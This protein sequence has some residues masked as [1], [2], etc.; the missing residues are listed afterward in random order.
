MKFSTIPSR[1]GFLSV[2]FSIIFYCN[3]SAGQCSNSGPHNGSV[4]TNN[5]SIGSFSFSSPGNAEVSDNNVASASALITLLNGNTHYLE[6]RGFGFAIPPSASICGIVVEVEKSAT[7]I[8]LF[9]YVEDNSVRLIKG[10]VITGNNYATSAN[11]TSSSSYHTYGGAT[12]KWGSTW[13]VADINA[14]NFGVAFSAAITGLATL[15]PGAHIDHIRVTVYFNI[16]L[17][18]TISEFKATAYDNHTTHLEWNILATE[19]NTTASVERKTASSAWQTIHSTAFKNSGADQRF[20]FIDSGCFASLAYYRLKIQSGYG[21]P[22]YSN[23]IPVRWNLSSLTIYP[24]PAKD[25]FFITRIRTEQPV[26]CISV[27]GRRWQLSTEKQGEVVRVDI[28]QLPLGVYAISVDGKK[29]L[30]L[31]K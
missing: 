4:F 18:S 3:N 31:K 1:T 27:D 19:N 25:E 7:G 26:Y 15:L 12:D 21:L 20:E 23:I 24:N 17:P 14:G 6:A 30:L 9:A 16:V 22:S 5:N 10:G 29:A 8:N 13:T 28:R 2:I 11:W